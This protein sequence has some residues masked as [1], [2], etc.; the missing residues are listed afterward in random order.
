MTS[1]RGSSSNNR[2]LGRAL[3]SLLGLPSLA[4]AALIYSAHPWIPRYSTVDLDEARLNAE[5]EARGLGT[6][7]THW[8]GLHVKVPRDFV[9]LRQENLLEVLDVDARDHGSQSWTIH[10]AFLETDSAAISRFR[11]ATDNC[12]LAP[13]R[14][15][16][17]SAGTHGANCQRSSGVPDPEVEWTPHLECQFEDLGIRVLINAPPD[18][19]PELLQIFKNAVAHSVITPPNDPAGS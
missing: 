11:A 15:W 8:H 6:R 1:P 18:R 16:A 2:S 13:D 10:M 17:D 19:I 4:L 12:G 9:L 3:L 5:R 7:L 14:C